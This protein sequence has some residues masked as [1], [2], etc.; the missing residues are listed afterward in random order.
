MGSQDMSLVA[1]AL[2]PARNSRDPNDGDWWSPSTHA[3]FALLSMFTKGALQPTV[4]IAP[5]L[6]YEAI[7]NIR[8]WWKGEISGQRCVK[9]LLD[10][11]ATVAGGMGGA[12][13][14]A[15]AGS[16][17]GPIGTGIGFLAGGV[18]GCWAASQLSKR[19][20]EKLFNLPRSVALENAYRYFGLTQ[21]CSN[22]DI[23]AAYKRLALVKHPDK[24]GSKEDFFELQVSLAIIKEHRE[25]L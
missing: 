12:W 13:A 11:M 25:G 23:N 9:N 1:K 8:A 21:S 6:A 10:D 17:F 2:I 20:T 18:T 14:G 3:P 4:I 15:A 7:M 22:G 16:I 24:G 19:L 5:K